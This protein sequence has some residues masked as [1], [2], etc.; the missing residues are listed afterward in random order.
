MFIETQQCLVHTLSVGITSWN[1]TFEGGRDCNCGLGR[2]ANP[3]SECLASIYYQPAPQPGSL[4]HQQMPR[5]LYHNQH[6]A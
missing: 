5:I 2:V 3:G 4:P 6:R 1:W